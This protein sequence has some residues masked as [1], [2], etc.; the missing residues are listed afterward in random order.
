MS[1][2]FLCGIECEHP[3]PPFNPYT[4]FRSLT[5]YKCAQCGFYAVD[6]AV[7][8][9]CRANEIKELTVLLKGMPNNSKPFILYV[10]DSTLGDEDFITNYKDD[11]DLFKVCDPK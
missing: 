11:Y 2:C 9:Q 10:H 7:V 8:A 1:K 4:H 5:W 6:V 3:A